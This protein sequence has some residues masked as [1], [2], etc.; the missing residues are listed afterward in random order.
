MKYEQRLEEM[1]ELAKINER[2]SQGWCRPGVSERQRRQ[3]W[4]LWR[5]WAE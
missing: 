2:M 5:E 1:K 3:E 4:L